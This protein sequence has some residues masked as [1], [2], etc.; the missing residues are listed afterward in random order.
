MLLVMSIRLL[1]PL[2]HVSPAPIV[3]MPV[4]E[5]ATMPE[6]ATRPSPSKLAPAPT[7]ITPPGGPSRVT[8][9]PPVSTVSAAARLSVPPLLT[10]TSPVDATVE[11]P[12]RARNPSTVNVP[13]SVNAPIEAVVTA[14]SDGD[15]PAGTMAASPGPGTAP[16]LQFAATFHAASGAGLVNVAMVDGGGVVS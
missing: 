6:L 5:N 8:T 3:L 9:W 11:S 16:V 12:L 15:V 4:P 14:A 13:A 2:V 7:A 10:N 1:V